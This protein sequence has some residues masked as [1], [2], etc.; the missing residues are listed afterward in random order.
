MSISTSTVIGERAVNISVLELNI[1][2]I[3]NIKDREALITDKENT[4]FYGQ[5]NI[6]CQFHLI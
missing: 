3:Y 4:Q 5:N 1:F 2:Q 6:V